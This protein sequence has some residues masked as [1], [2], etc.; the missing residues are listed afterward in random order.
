[1]PGVCVCVKGEGEARGRKG[2]REK[3]PHER[4]WGGGER[5]RQ[6]RKQ[7]IEVTV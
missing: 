5:G 2:Q 3:E 6:G 7:V 1:M 4:Q